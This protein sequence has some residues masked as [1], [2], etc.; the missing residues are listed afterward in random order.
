VNGFFPLCRRLAPLVLALLLLAGP[1]LAAEIGAGLDEAAPVTIEADAL[2]FDEATST[3]RATGRVQLRKGRLTLLSDRL[4]WNTAT[5]KAAAHGNV[6]LSEAGGS[7]EGEELLL[8][9][10]SGRGRLTEGTVLIKEQNFHI[11]GAEIEKLGDQT[12]RVKDGTFTT[13]DG[14]PP[15]W[16][17]AA[18][19]FDVTL[20][21][22][23]RAKHVVFY[24][25]DIPVLYTP[26]LLYPV[27]TERQSGFL[28][29]RY[30]YSQKRGTELSLAYYQVID[31]HLDATFY[32]DYLADL[33]VGKGLEYRYILG[34][35]NEGV[36]KAYHVTGLK[37]ADNRYAFDWLHHGTL[38]GSVRLAAD[39]EYVSSRDYFDDF[40]EVAGE[41]NKDKAQSVVTA[42]RNWGKLNLTGQLKYTKDLEQNNESTLQRLPEINLAAIRRRLGETPFYTALDSSY[43][44]FWRQEGLKG[45]RLTAR[46]ALSA[47]FWPWPLL[48]I[49]PELGFRQRLYWTSSDG[50]GF[51][52]EG[53]FDF[54][55]RLSSRFSRVF[56]PDRK[57]VKKIRHSIEPEITYRYVPSENQDHL[58]QFDAL[59]DIGPENKLIYAL[60]NR[61][62][63]RLEPESGETVYHEFLY[64]RLSQDYDIRESRRDRLNPEDRLHPFSDIRM[65]LI[66]RPTR[67]SYI[68]L[69]GRYDV[70]SRVNRFLVFNARGGAQDG[71]GNGLSLDYRYR[72]D[73]LEYAA[74]SLDL[75]LLR[76]VYVKYQH[77][78]DFEAGRTLERV[79]DLEYRSQCWSIF[80]TARDRLEGKEYLITF[81]L[82]GLGKVAEFGGSLGRPEEEPPANV[83]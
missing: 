11:A 66:A 75:A 36:A 9:L 14:T 70:D 43:T 4:E 64:L 74:G 38:P 61:F 67:W 30:G 47:V 34:E 49:Q 19:R 27:K 6:R 23:A 41:Y 3:Y 79:L 39:V 16:K 31:R 32:L 78:Y 81:A 5:G 50:P 20:E 48:E 44:Y 28:T 54:S 18:R 26:Y 62:T 53:L 68:D 29:P 12:Y 46:P 56:L 21:G 69:D 63:A 72:H 35:D 37:D 57:V 8:D 73:D 42:S 22:Y 60:T 58:P 15:S 24:L 59:D 51:E 10:D 40:G 25:R 77:R 65:E 1:S 33:G 80:L 45:Q 17:F 76:P 2:T 7:L 55:T 71:A 82:S 83:Y 13:C 52:R